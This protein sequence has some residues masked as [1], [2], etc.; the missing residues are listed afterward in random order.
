LELDTNSF[1]TE[2]SDEDTASTILIEA[3]RFLENSQRVRARSSRT[4]N[5]SSRHKRPNLHKTTK[6]KAKSFGGHDLSV[7][8]REE[9][10]RWK[11]S[12]E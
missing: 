9:I 5:A 6:A 12:G 10:K 3:E 8:P 4:A 1:D 2:L 7:I 11:A